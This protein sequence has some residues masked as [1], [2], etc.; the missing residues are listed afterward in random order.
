M[1]EYTIQDKKGNVLTS[2]MRFPMCPRVGDYVII[3]TIERKV[4]KVIFSHS[5][6]PLIIVK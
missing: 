2:I 4:I 6:W 3:G 5:R 1:N